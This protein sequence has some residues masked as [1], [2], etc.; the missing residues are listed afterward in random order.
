MDK[1]QIQLINNLQ[2]KLIGMQLAHKLI[3]E[4]ENSVADHYQREVDFLQKRIF[5]LQ[6]EN[7]ESVSA[8]G[9]ESCVSHGVGNRNASG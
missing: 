7:T 5:I 6:S 3:T 2:H 1:N 8:S 4:F 9:G